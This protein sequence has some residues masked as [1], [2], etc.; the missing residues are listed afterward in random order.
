MPELANVI[1]FIMT[2][3]LCLLYSSWVAFGILIAYIF[4]RDTKFWEIKERPTP[5]KALTSK[6]FQHKYMTVN[7]IKIHYVEKGDP[8]KPLMLFVHGFPEFWF[9]WRYQ[10]KEFSEDYYCVAI[11]QRG[12]SESDKPTSISAYGIDKMVDDIREV[13]KQLGYKKFTLV[14][15]DWGAAIAFRYV[16][17]YMD[18]LEKYVC[19]GGPPSQVWQKN[20]KSSIKQFLMS[21]YMFFFQ[22]PYLPEFSSSLFDF[23]IFKVMKQNEEDTEAYRYTF[24]KPGALT[25][26]I[27][28]YRAL[29]GL[30]ILFPDKPLPKPSKFVPGL[31][32]LGEKDKYIM[33]STGKSA[34]QY[35]DNLEFKVIHGANHFAQQHKPEET[36]RLIRE[37]IEKK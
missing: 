31:F 18:T 17:R 26:P 35:Y 23:R 24:S 33:Q 4:K 37:F 30:N 2:Y 34:K 9:S 12:Y 6:E 14:A 28:Y 11:D 3:A 20:I 10:L 15:H 21:W 13:V 36:N 7:G 27:N 16:Y 8:K 19:I 29:G 32:M 22:M 25:G 5:P 1:R